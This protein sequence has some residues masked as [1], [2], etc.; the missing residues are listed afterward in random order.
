MLRPLRRLLAKGHDGA[1]GLGRLPIRAAWHILGRLRAVQ[2]QLL[3]NLG[4]EALPARAVLVLQPSHRTCRH[5]CEQQCQDQSWQKACSATKDFEPHDGPCPS[6]L[7]GKA[8][9]ASSPTALRCCLTCN[10]H[11]GPAKQ[12]ACSLGAW[13]SQLH[14]NKD[15]RAYGMQRWQSD[16][17][18]TPPGIGWGCVR[19]P[20]GRCSPA[21][22]GCCRSPSLL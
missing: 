19:C 20:L 14:V 21:G 10:K 13:C 3:G 11:Q 8:K 6:Y 16:A 4:R 22:S 15:V 2:A 7:V 9:R 1:I 12:R 5:I 17:S 18:V